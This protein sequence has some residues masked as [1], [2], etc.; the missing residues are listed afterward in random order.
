MATL[1]IRYVENQPTQEGD[2]ASKIQRFDIVSWIIDPPWWTGD[3]LTSGLILNNP[4]HTTRTLIITA[5]PANIIA[6][7]EAWRD[8]ATRDDRVS[9]LTIRP[10]GLNGPDEAYLNTHGWL[11]LPYNLTTLR[12]IIKKKQVNNSADPDGDTDAPGNF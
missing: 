3:P 10:S 1:V 12:K 8:A 5:I 6:Q 7:V 9:I 4:N 11:V 2:A